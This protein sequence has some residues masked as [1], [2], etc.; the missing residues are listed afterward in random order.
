MIKPFPLCL[1]SALIAG[2]ACQ[3]Q[4]GHTYFVIKDRK[5]RNIFHLNDT[6]HLELTG[7]RA[8]RQADSAEWMI[9]GRTVKNGL[10]LTL[11]ASELG[12]GSTKVESVVWQDEKQYETTAEMVVLS[13]TEPSRY[14][15]RVMAVYGHDT[16]AYTQ[17]LCYS[18]G[19]LYEGTGRKG[20][21]VLRI[22]GVNGEVRR[23]VRLPDNIF[24]EGVC[25]LD[26]RIYQLSWKGEKGFIYKKSTL[27]KIGEF[28][29]PGP[30]DGWGLT[31]DGRYLMM[32]DGTHRIHFLDP[33]DSMKIVRTIEVF[34]NQNAVKL[35]N[36]L[37][38]VDGLIYANVY[39]KDY[40]V[41]IDP[42]S[43]KVLRQI[44]L[45]GLLPENDHY[46]GFDKYNYVLNGIAYEP[47][48]GHFYI[49]GKKWPKL[50][51]VTFVAQDTVAGR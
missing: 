26:D 37:E 23:E 36:E 20:R 7:A 33:R 47:G 28:P 17:G 41:G 24:G 15:Y 5:N 19:Q 25:L 8:G 39:T 16:S 3:T 42:E 34:D 4:N 46:P 51:E 9:D 44:D 45:A 30:F 27:E 40:I 2:S 12:L 18:G 10:Q 11:P 38:Y 35:L 50:F 6:L 1:L 43:G 21:S 49:T 32:S 29:Y 31:T 13:D 14:T 22:T 48:S